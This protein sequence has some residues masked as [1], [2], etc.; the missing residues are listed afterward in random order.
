MKNNNLIRA[1]AK[2]AGVKLWQIADAIGLSDGNFSRK[3]RHELPADEQ[4][5]ILGIIEELSKEAS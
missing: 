1:A 3:L 4:E 5:R 2:S